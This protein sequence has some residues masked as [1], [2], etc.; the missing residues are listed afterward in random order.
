MFSRM[1]MPISE[2]K[3]FFRCPLGRILA[4]GRGKILE[5][6]REKNRS[7][8]TVKNL[9]DTFVLMSTFKGVEYEG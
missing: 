3:R 8:K 1:G 7:Y 2:S 5:G 9:L 6:I 4:E